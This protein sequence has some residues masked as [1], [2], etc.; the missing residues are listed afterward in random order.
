MATLEFEAQYPNP[1]GATWQDVRFTRDDVAAG[2]HQ[3]MVLNSRNAQGIWEPKVASGH[4][5]TARAETSTAPAAPRPPAVPGIPSVVRVGFTDAVKPGMDT[6][7]FFVRLG[8]RYSDA[9]GAP[10]ANRF[11]ITRGFKSW[12]GNG[13]SYNNPTLQ[14]Q[15]NFLANRYKGQSCFNLD[16][17]NPQNLDPVSGCPADGVTAV[18]PDGNCPAPS[19]KDATISPPVCVCPRD[20]LSAASSGAS[21]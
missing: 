21:R 7:P 14:Q 5:Y 10:P 19:T 18:P 12:G 1:G 2:A 16:H 8:I 11:T 15:F 17:Q 13:V 4:G 9:N 3:S 20:T 6:K